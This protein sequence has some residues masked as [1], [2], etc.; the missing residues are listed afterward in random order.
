ME[1]PTAKRNTINQRR[2]RAR[3]QV[4]IEDL[5]RRIRAYETQGVQATAEVQTA[6]RKVAEENRALREEVKALQEQNEALQRSLAEHSARPPQKD[7]KVD[8]DPSPD[9]RRKIRRIGSTRKSRMFDGKTFAQGPSFTIFRTPP[10][11]DHETLAKLP[12]ASMTVSTTTT[13]SPQPP[14]LLA[15]GLR[16]NT[17]KLHDILVVDGQAREDRMWLPLAEEGEGTPSFIPSPPHSNFAHS[18]PDDLS[19][20]AQHPY[21][22]PSPAV[23]PFESKPKLCQP[24]ST[25]N[26]TPCLEAALIIASMRGVPSNDIVVETEILPELGCR[27]PLSRPRCISPDDCVEHGHGSESSGDR[28]SADRD[29]ETCA[30][31]NRR[32]FGI[33]AREE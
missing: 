28:N 1:A 17:L 22:P 8:G 16:P 27:G 19:S 3:R 24:A 2:C 12:S 10:H 20:T 14:P 13:L 11:Q 5:E 25:A 9:G 7:D 32:L 30:V 21:S 23:S 4:Y 15:P 6:A 31:D 26:S 18:D 29:L 33:L